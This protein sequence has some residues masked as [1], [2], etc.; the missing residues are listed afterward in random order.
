MKLIKV[1][2]TFESILITFLKY[3]FLL[4]V[5]VSSTPPSFHTFCSQK[6]QGN[7]TE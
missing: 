3:L 6:E 2:V 5:T 4:Q 1:Y 7:M